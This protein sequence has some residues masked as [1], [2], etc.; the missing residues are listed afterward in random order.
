MKIRALFLSF[1][2]FSHFPSFFPSFPLFPFPPPPPSVCLPPI[3]AQLVERWTV[4]AEISRA[5]WFESGSKDYFFVFK[6]T[7]IET[8]A[9]LFSHAEKS[10]CD[11]SSCYCFFQFLN[12]FLSFLFSH[13]EK[14]FPFVCDVVLKLL[15]GQ[16]DPQIS[17]DIASLLLSLADKWRTR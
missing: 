4:V 6:C 2:L 5:R 17:R 7:L 11:V 10:L 8:Q 16:S 3:L 9:I 1:L 14:Y 12:V 13:A 15:L